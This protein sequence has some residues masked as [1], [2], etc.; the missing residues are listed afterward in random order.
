MASKH[1]G[2]AIEIF[3][4]LFGMAHEG[5]DVVIKDGFDGSELDFHDYMID[6]F[7]DV[8]DVV[9]DIVD[10]VHEEIAQKIV[11]LLILL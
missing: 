5:W 1:A 7:L 3:K 6:A 2:N 10:E 8:F 4:G 11:F 9:V